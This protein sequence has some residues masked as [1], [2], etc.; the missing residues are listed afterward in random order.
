MADLESS[1]LALCQSCPEVRKIYQL[2]LLI[3]IQGI[4]DK[5]F[6]ESHPD[7]PAAELV[8]VINSLSVAGLLEMVKGQNGTLLYRAI[9]QEDAFM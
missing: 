4:S 1:F 5:K 6:R 8:K 3:K 9:K 7:V 2:F